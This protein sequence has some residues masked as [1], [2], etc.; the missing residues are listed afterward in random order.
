MPSAFAKF[1]HSRTVRL[2]RLE[3]KFFHKAMEG[4]GDCQAAVTYVK[5]SERRATLAGANA[6]IGH[7]VQVLQSTPATQETSTDRIEAAIARIRG[8]PAKPH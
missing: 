3:L 5:I 2:H 4:E 8:L 1:G 6:P 7:V